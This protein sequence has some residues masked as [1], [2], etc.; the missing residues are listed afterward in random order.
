MA[1]QQARTLIPEDGIPYPGKQSV[2]SRCRSTHHRTT[3]TAQ[4]ACCTTCVDTLPRRIRPNAFRPLVPI[5]IKSACSL[6][7]A[8]MISSAGTPN[9]H[10]GSA[11]KPGLNKLPHAL[12]DDLVARLLLPRVRNHRHHVDHVHMNW[13]VCVRVRRTIRLKLISVQTLALSPMRLIHPWPR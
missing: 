11:V 8:F 12:L 5:T 9:R 6:A 3:S 2:I 7:A 13:C 4:C 1:L 10:T